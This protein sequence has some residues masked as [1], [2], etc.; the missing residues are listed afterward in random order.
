VSRGNATKI[1]LTIAALL[2]ISPAFGARLNQA[3]VD[4]AEPSGKSTQSDKPTPIGVRVQVLLDRARFSPGEI[5]G[6]LGENARKALRAFAEFQQLP[7]S[8]A[9]TDEVWRA[10]RTDDRPVTKNYTIADKDV[11][12]PFLKKTSGQDGGPEGYS[13]VGLHQPSRGTSREVSYE[14][15]AAGGP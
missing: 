4:A 11:A 1:V 9:L 6:K 5:D 13:E 8:D 10:L 14:R 7:S 12:G 15:T 2:A 3:S